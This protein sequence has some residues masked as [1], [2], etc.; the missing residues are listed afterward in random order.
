M[1]TLGTAHTEHLLRIADLRP[2]SSP[3][4]STSPPR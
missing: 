3:S 2:A 4:C 1:T